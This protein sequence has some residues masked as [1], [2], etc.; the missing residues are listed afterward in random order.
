MELSRALMTAVPTVALWVLHSVGRWELKLADYLAT[1][2]VRWLGL[3]LAGQWDLHLVALW[4]QKRVGQKE[5]LSAM[6]LG[7]LKGKT[8]GCRLVAR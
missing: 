1:K 4:D 6:K 5:L 7:S 8:L 2:R 3:R